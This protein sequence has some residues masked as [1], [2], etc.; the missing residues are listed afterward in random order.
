MLCETINHFVTILQET[1][2]VEDA[3]VGEE[4]ISWLVSY[5]HLRRRS[6]VYFDR[7]DQHAPNVLLLRHPQP[8]FDLFSLRVIHTN[9]LI[10][11][12]YYFNAN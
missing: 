7:F 4:F 12:D 8:H 5:Y 6:Q 10:F 9:W 11:K 3:F 2:D 1:S